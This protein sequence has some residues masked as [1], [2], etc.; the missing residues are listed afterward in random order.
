MR[1]RELITVLGGAAVG[2]PLTARAQQPATPVIGIFEAGGDNGD[3]H[4]VL[5]LLIKDGAENDVGILVGGALN[6]AA[7]L[8]YFGKF[9]RT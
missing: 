5:H 8:L 6:D 2:W 3:F 7:G 1:R 9:E 4:R